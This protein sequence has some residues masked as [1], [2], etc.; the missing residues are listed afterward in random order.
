MCAQHPHLRLV[1]CRIT[2]EEFLELILRRAEKIHGVVAKDVD[3]LNDELREKVKNEILVS[4]K[5]C[6]E[7]GDIITRI[8]EWIDRAQDAL[9]VSGRSAYT[10]F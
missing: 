3:D 6:E 2:Q 10:P 9:V 7:N 1:K 4:R 8:S 5:E